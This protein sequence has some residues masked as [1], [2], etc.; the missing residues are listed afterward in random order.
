MFAAQE[1]TVAALFNDSIPCWILIKPERQALEDDSRQ[2]F[3]GH[4]DSV[5][6][7][8]FS[9]DASLIASVSEDCTIR[10]W[11]VSDGKCL[12]K[13]IGHKDAIFSVAFFPKGDILVS[14][15]Q[16][17][18]VRLWSVEDGRCLRRLRGHNSAVNQVVASPDGQFVT[19]CSSLDKGDGSGKIWIWS[20][21]ER[22]CLHEWQGHWGTVHSVDFSSDSELVTFGTADG[23]I[24]VWRVKD[25]VCIYTLEGHEEPVHSA[26]FAPDLSYLASSS[27]DGTVRIWNFAEEQCQ[28]VFD[29]QTW[30]TTISVSPD[31]KQI[32]AASSDNV[33]QIWNVEQ[34]RCEYELIGHTSYV[35]S[36]VFS[37]D[38]KLLVS[39]SHDFTVRVWPANAPPKKQKLDDKPRGLG[40]I[41]VSPDHSIIASAE[42]AGSI[43]LWDFRGGGMI[44]EMRAAGCDFLHVDEF[45]FS[46]DGKRLLVLGY[47][48]GSVGWLWSVDD[49]E[50]IH[51]FTEHEWTA[52]HA[53]FL[54]DS[55]TVI[56]GC[57]DY[58]IR[59]WNI[60][61]GFMDELIGHE[62]AIS[63]VSVSKNPEMLACGDYGGIVRLWDP[64]DG[65]VLHKLHGP[66]G[67][68]TTAV[69]Y[70]GGELLAISYSDNTI[71]IWNTK[72]GICAKMLTSTEDIGSVSFAPD[73]AFLVS[74]HSDDTVRIWRIE[75]ETCLHAQKFPRIGSCDIEFNGSGSQL[76][77]DAGQLLIKG[78]SA[79]DSTIEL[80][81][82]GL[83]LSKDSRWV[84]WRGKK[85][86]WLPSS[87]HPSCW[88]IRESTVAI[89]CTS[90]RVIVIRFGD[91]P[92]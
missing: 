40:A 10:I 81:N 37:P 51:D 12:H 11:R 77:F 43:K 34:T 16:D 47:S 92:V 35:N 32:S 41:I 86:L 89:G 83:A 6:S 36:T 31:S 75:D 42:L 52:N 3:E 87:V 62:S 49:G 5:T 59:R 68:T 78:L 24:Y 82:T 64:L 25:G 61:D 15:C 39:G 54:R 14:G 84:T 57:D 48:S 56:I 28:Q 74:T 9:P 29:C 46:P 73:L 67:E 13:L 4:Q 69:F 50:C 2:V 65:T 79:A 33:I 80:V 72:T 63:V 53:T 38:A 30:T 58:V 85:I 45:Q 44:R 71:R 66:E 88:L 60:E 7:S 27:A 21:P 26:V 8:V 19:F 91:V 90:G 17:K 55:K 70:Q 23:L 1:N 76:V 22:E 20:I 18:S